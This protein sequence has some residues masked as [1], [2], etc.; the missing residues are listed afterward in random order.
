MHG[1]SSDQRQGFLHEADRVVK[2]GGV[3]A[4][5]EIVKAET[6]FG[7]PMAIRLSPEELIQTVGWTPKV[8][9][10]VGEYFYMQTFE[11]ARSVE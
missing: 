3:L 7:P 6:P 9:V 5:V 2:P 8:C 11:K 4:I 1:F 10:T